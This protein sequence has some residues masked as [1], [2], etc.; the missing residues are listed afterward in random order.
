MPVY[1]RWCLVL[2]ELVRWE[3][4]VWKEGIQAGSMLAG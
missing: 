4:L 1:V 2:S 3:Q